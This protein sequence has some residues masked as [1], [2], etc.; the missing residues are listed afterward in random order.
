ML[1]NAARSFSEQQSGSSPFGDAL[2][3]DRVS[4]RAAHLNSRID[5]ASQRCIV[6]AL[7]RKFRLAK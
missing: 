2:S 7:D 1:P 6:V 4:H 3:R 5:D